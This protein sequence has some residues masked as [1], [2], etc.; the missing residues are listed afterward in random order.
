MTPRGQVPVTPRGQ[1]H[2]TSRGQV[3]VTPRGLPVTPRGGV[4]GQTPRG[5]SRANMMNFTAGLQMQEETEVTLFELAALIRQT[6]L[7]EKV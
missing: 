2:V 3:P 4:F 6:A 7:E 1:V 5:A